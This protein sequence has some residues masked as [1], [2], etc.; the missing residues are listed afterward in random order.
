MI[1]AGLG[2]TTGLSPVLAKT[3]L[4]L[5]T[6]I[7]TIGGTS[8]LTIGTL[9]ATEVIGRSMKDLIERLNYV[10]E[11]KNDIQT[12][13]DVFARDFS[14]KSSRRQ[15]DFIKRIDDL[16]ANM[17]LK[18]LVILELDANWESKKKPTDGNIKKTFKDFSSEDEP[19]NN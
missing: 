15:G 6:A 3:D 9:E 12:K 11:K 2:A 18:G 8:T 16:M 4:D 19:K 17:S 10:I 7:S 5:R 13:G 14:L 1:T